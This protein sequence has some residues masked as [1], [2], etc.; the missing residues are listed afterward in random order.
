MKVKE[1]RHKHNIRR[2]NGITLIALIIT[3]VILIIL[4]TVAINITVGDN[5]LMQRAEQAKE[6]TEQVTKEEE[7]QINSATE[8]I[9]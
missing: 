8:K 7:E 3:I 6:L 1:H 4:A 5:G 9:E 2:Q